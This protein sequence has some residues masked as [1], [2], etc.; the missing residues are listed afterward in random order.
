MII[1]RMRF[2]IIVGERLAAPETL[3]KI[4]HP[5]AKQ[6]KRIVG[7]GTWARVS[8]VPR[9]TGVSDIESPR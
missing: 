9:M 6:M 3:S 8:D 1:S 4:S 7:Y 5:N 2:N